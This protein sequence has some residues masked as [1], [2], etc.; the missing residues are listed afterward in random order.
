MIRKLRETINIF[1]YD[2][3]DRALRMLSILHLVVSLIS[4]G[5]LIYYYGFPLDKDTA[6]MLFRVIEI[7]FGFYILRYLLKLFYDFNPLKFLRSSWFEALLL[8]LLAVEGISWNV[9][10]QHLIAPIFNRLRLFN[11]EDVSTIFL[12]L[13]FFTY[14]IADVYKRSRKRLWARLHPALLFMISIAG[15]IIIGALLLMLPEMSTIVGGMPFV[16]ALF[17][18]ASSV[19][20]T[21]LTTFDVSADLTFKGQAVILFL[22]KIG[23]LNT[24]AFGA[25][26][27]LMARFGV[28]VKQHEVIEDFVNKQSIQNAGGIFRKIIIWATA[29][30]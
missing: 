1:I 26:L 15:L 25:L 19:S 3:K 29:I 17:M 24:I 4:V 18:S 30:E 10:G 16:D 7:S 13:F 20:V 9:F 28:G 22:I 5:T 8:L 11:F 21:G 6:R 12:Q 14:I 27:F 2:S 23:G